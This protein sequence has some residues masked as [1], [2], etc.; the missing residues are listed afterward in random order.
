MEE[1]RWP[2]ASYWHWVPTVT[3]PVDMLTWPCHDLDPGHM[4]EDGQDLTD[5]PI[6]VERLVS[7]HYFIH[8]GRHRAIRAQRAGEPFIKAKVIP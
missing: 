6:L 7:G 1:P 2:A 4:H 8:D 5:G 3:V